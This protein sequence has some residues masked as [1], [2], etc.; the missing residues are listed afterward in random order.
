MPETAS[1]DSSQPATWPKVLQ[2]DGSET[3][4]AQPP[5]I[6]RTFPLGLEPYA[7][8][9]TGYLLIRNLLDDTTPADH[10]IAP[11]A[12]LSHSPATVLTGETVDFDASASTDPDGTVAAY[13]Q[14]VAAAPERMVWGTNW[15][16]FRIVLAEMS[17][18]QFRVAVLLIG[19]AVLF[20]M[21]PLARGCSTLPPTPGRPRIGASWESS[22]VWKI[23]AQSLKLSSKLVYWSLWTRAIMHRRKVRS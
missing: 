23:Q 19:T 7:V 10:N 6:M 12:A 2:A 21:M 16:L 14:V 18:W 9:Y 4:M 8:T 3:D 20:A 13:E 17:V 11:I 22:R 5:E 15:P 1:P